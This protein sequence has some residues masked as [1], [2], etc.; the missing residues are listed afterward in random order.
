MWWRGGMIVLTL[1]VL[2]ATTRAVMYV[3][4]QRGV[5]VVIKHH[6]NGQLAERRE[7]RNGREDGVHRGWHANG[8]LR[9]V[10]HYVNG[11]AEGVQEDWYPDGAPYTRFEYVAGH[12]EGRQQ[13]WT[14]KG[15]LRANY[16]VAHGRRFGLMGT[17]GCM[18][19]AHD[20]SRSV[21]TAAVR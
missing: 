5:T 20:D 14:A 13:M 19:T 12:E 10:Y 18:G 2:T 11:V 16:V 6:P 8:A 15:V 17:T 3:V 9:F 4:D 21:V 7:Y 1:L